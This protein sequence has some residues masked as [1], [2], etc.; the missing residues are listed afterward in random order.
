[1]KKRAMDRGTETAKDKAERHVIRCAMGIVNSEG[2]AFGLDNKVH[3]PGSMRR[4]ES[5][6]ARLKEA[7]RAAKPRRTK[8]T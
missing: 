5:A 3:F 1:M 6:I 8:Y 4:L 2:W 7:R